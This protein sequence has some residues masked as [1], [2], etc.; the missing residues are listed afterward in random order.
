[1]LKK[2]K[3]IIAILA[4]LLLILAC[5]FYLYVS[6]Y[7]KAD[8]QARNVSL[9]DSLN[10]QTSKN[11]TTIYPDPAV[12]KQIGL[13]FYPGGKVESIAYL[14]L[15]SL[16]SQEGLTSVLVTMPFNL[17]VFNKD[18]AENVIEA[19]P[20]IEN[21][22]LAGHSLGGAMASS[23]VEDQGSTIKGLILLGAYP[24]NDADVPTLA[25]Y[26]SE[27][28]KLDI[29]KLEKTDQVIEIVGG[30]HAYF[31]NYGLQEGDGTATISRDEQ[32]K[33]AVTEI[34]NFIHQINK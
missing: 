16:L 18:A 26:G 9:S 14:P 7:Y 23:F 15:L 1:M 12:D 28:I 6:D 34:I 2:K 13:I 5:F 10:I 27:D 29:S 3:R 17:A 4:L 11:L 19:V 25:I 33:V 21:W 24:I 20:T 22:F 31:G 8:E 30:N 32:Q